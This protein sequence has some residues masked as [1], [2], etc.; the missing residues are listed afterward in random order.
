MFELLAP[1][2]RLVSVMSTAA[3]NRTDKRGKQFFDLFESADGTF[4][5]LARGTFAE[6]GTDVPALIVAMTA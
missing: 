5:P 2:G 1:G 6:S 4:R 3:M